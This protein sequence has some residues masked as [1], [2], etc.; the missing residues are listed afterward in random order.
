[1]RVSGGKEDPSFGGV[2]RWEQGGGNAHPPHRACRVL[3]GGVC[4]RT[5]LTGA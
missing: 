5:V 4:V 2:L 3:L 1:M